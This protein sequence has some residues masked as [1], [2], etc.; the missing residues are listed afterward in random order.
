L[1][2]IIRGR[3]SGSLAGSASASD[4]AQEAVMGLLKTA[5]QPS[6]ADPR[7]LRG[8]LWRS[9][10]HLLVKRFEKKSRK[11]A[12]LDLE[13]PA[14]IDRFLK[15]AD[16]LADIDRAERAMAIGLALNLLPP[17]N[18]RLLELVYF[19]NQDIATAGAA[20]GMTRDAASSRLARTRRLLASRLSDWSNLIG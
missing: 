3:A 17:D 11:P 19:E 7:A 1:K 2:H 9:A 18:R 12:K 16:A 10:W 5:K 14:A 13:D 6:F 20:L 4:I 8:Y 15:G